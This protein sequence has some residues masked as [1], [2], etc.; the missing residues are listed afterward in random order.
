MK[1]HFVFLTVIT[2]TGLFVFTSGCKN[3]IVNPTESN[4]ERILFLSSYFS[5]NTNTKSNIFIINIDGTELKQLTFGEDYYSV[6]PV[7][8]SDGAKIIFESIGNGERDIYSMNLDGSNRFNLTNSP[9][10]DVS[11][12]VTN[13][14][15]FIIFERYEIINGF[16]QNS[17]IYKMGIDGSNPINLTNNSYYCHSPLVSPDDN[18]II[19]TVYLTGRPYLFSMNLDGSN[20]TS[21]TDS[22]VVLSDLPDNYSISSDGRKLVFVGYNQLTEQKDIF[23]VNIDGS[24]LINLTNDKELE[25]RPKFSNDNL[26]IIYDVSGHSGIDEIRPIK[27]IPTSG[28][29]SRT[30]INYLNASSPS[31][32]GSDDKI[33]F[34]A[35]EDDNYDIFSVNLDG[36]NLFNITNRKIDDYNPVPIP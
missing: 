1:K 8:T 14:N 32:L 23:L 31:Y 35:K 6:S 5:N 34:V 7:V 22:S 36:E 4:T 12:S 28:G 16:V 27:V 11:P 19:Y 10:I 18:K 25:S 2:I 3:E 24:S 9:G 29:N 15:K 20:Q 21:L 30:I 17:Q 13:D 33:L 26:N